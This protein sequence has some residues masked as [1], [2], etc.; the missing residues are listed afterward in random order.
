MKKFDRDTYRRNLKDVGQSID[1][2]PFKIE[3]YLRG[4]FDIA[5]SFNTDEQASGILDKNDL[6]QECYLALVE[7]WAN[8]N[9]KEFEKADDPQAYAWAYLKKSIKLK[10]RQK[11]HD[12]KDGV[13]IPHYTRWEIIETKNVDDFL[14]QLFPTEWFSDNAESLDLIDYGYNTR[15]DIEQLGLAFQDIFRLNLSKKEEFIINAYFGLESDKL[16]S[17]TIANR[18]GI[19]VSNVDKTKFTALKKLKTNEIKNYLKEF[20]EFE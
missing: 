9:M 17:K 13:R 14:T 8:I 7:A 19:T 16:S 15:Y 18:L 20:Y 11:I 3:T 2:D 5:N 12:K 4:A 1:N 10:A 6:A